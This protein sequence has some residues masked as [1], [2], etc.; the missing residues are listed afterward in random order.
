MLQ[1]HLPDIAEINYNPATHIVD[2]KVEAKILD[3]PET[4]AIIQAIREITEPDIFAIVS[5]FSAVDNVTIEARRLFAEKDPR[6]VAVAIVIDSAAKVMMINL[7]TRLFAMK[8]NFKHFTD[9]EQ[10]YKWIK[11]QLNKH[12]PESS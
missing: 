6:L 8:Y 9:K 7:M 2:V 11:G 5:D 10:A 1:R 12:L 4:L 3:I